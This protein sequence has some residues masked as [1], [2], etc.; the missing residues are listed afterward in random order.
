MALLSIGMFVFSVSTVAYDQVQRRTDWRHARNARVG[1]RSAAQFVGPGEDTISLSGT[2][3]SEI[4]DGSVSIDDL[5]E[6]ADTG[7]AQQLVTGDGRVM[8]SF[9][10]TGIDV[11]ASSFWPDG[12]PRSIE[13]G[14]DLS[15][16]DPPSWSAA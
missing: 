14:I 2:V 8:G 6:K 9:I 15:Q 1:A 4:S 16:V 11:R 10:I 7:D 12:S 3:S 5:R 13:F